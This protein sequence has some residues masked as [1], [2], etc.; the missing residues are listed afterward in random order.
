MDNLLEVRQAEIRRHLFSTLNLKK[1]PSLK[2]MCRSRDLRVGGRKADVVERLV[3]DVLKR[4]WT[5]SADSD[6]WNNY[7]TMPESPADRID[8]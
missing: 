1:V 6:L 7:S 4:G 2:Q 3:L 8:P 5:V